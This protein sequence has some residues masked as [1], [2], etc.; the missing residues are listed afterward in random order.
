[1]LNIHISNEII[2][3]VSGYFVHYIFHQLINYLNWKSKNNQE[4][5]QHDSTENNVTNQVDFKKSACANGDDFE[6]EDEEKMSLVAENCEL[7]CLGQTG[8]D[9]TSNMSDDMRGVQSGSK[10][11]RNDSI[12]DVELDNLSVGPANVDQATVDVCG[13]FTLEQLT[14]LIVINKDWNKTL[15]CDLG[16]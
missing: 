3:F 15:V 13:Q 14:S 7:K 16:E 8:V 4:C 2:F 12:C 6:I 11:T 1:M 5:P 10:V 9:V